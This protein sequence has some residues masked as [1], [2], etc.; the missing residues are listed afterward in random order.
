MQLALA[1]LSQ[2]QVLKLFDELDALTREPFHAAKAEI[3]A[4]LARQC[5]VSVDELRPWH[6]HDPFFQESPAIYGN[7]ESVYRQID[8]VKV[9]RKF[10]E[11]IGLPIDDVLARSDLFEKP[12]K[13]PHAFS[14]DIDR[15]GDVRVLANVVP[16]QEWLATMLHECG[17]AAYSKNIPRSVPYVLR[18]ESHALTTEGVAM[19]FERLAGDARWLQAMGVRRAGRGEVRRRVA[20]AAPQ[21]AADLLPLV[22]GRVPLRDGPVR[23][24]RAGPEPRLVGPGGE[25]PGSEAARGAQPARLRQQ[26]PHR[27]RPGLLPELHAGRSCSPR[28]CITPSPATCSTAPTRRRPFTWA[29]RPSA[30]SCASGSSSPAARWTGTSSRGTPPARS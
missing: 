23:Q 18:I 1:E 20:Q 21:Q 7:F 8:T 26:D 12:G 4:A 24:S 14:T 16:G 27:H 17:H 11:G 9:V 28:R 19:M 6:Y 22:P 25:V 15:E 10:Y 13:C 3:D 29:I 5:G 30:G 2:E